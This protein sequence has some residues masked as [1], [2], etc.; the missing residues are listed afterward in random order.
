M[1][2]FQAEEGTLL[3]N[4]PQ[5]T[6]SQLSDTSLDNLPQT[7]ASPTFYTIFQLKQFLEKATGISI[8]NQILLDSKGAKVDNEQNISDIGDEE[9]H[10]YLFDRMSFS[11]KSKSQVLLKIISDEYSLLELKE[12]T[13]F[14]L[15]DDIQKRIK[16]NELFKYVQQFYVQM[17]QAEVCK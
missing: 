15:T 6:T 16:N 8:E 17:L 14:T 13:A 3:L 4:I 9:E 7:T 11:S 12:L 5:T 10:I 1:K 2:V